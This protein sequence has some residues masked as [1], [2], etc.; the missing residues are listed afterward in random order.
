MDV[1]MFPGDQ[2]KSC[3]SIAKVSMGSISYAFQYFSV[4]HASDSSSI[5]SRMTLGQHPYLNKAVDASL[6]ANAF[7]IPPPHPTS[8]PDPEQ[9]A[10]LEEMCN[11]GVP[12]I[13]I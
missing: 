10:L 1:L 5:L 11:I 12:Q 7:A 8:H 13:A 4:R 9:R 3:K 2:F 6:H